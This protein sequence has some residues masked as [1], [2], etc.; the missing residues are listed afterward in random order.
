MSM[1]ISGARGAERPQGP[2][3]F[4]NILNI[5]DADGDGQLSR[6]EFK[7]ILE[8]KLR[9]SFDEKRF[10]KMFEDMSGG[11]GFVSK[12]DHD[13]FVKKMGHNKPPHR[14]HGFLNN[15]ASDGIDTLS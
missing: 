6:N 1:P 11:D 2:P 8:D 15:K 3:K 13:D 14:R 7:T 9:D 4:E 10:T 5:G 12:E